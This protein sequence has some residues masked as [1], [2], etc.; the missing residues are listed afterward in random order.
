MKSK[1]VD[2]T[3]KS[4]LCCSCGICKSVC[5]RKCIEYKRESGMYI[6]VIDGSLCIKCGICTDVCPGL[7]HKYTDSDHIRSMTGESLLS[8]NAWSTD[9][10]LRH[11]SASAGC[12]SSLI[13]GLLKKRLYDCAVSVDT[14]DYS[15][16]VKSVVFD[17]NGIESE[18]S[19][20]DYPKSRYLPVS[21]ERA[22]EY[23]LENRDKRVIFVGT[24]CAVRGLV[25]VIEKFKLDRD[26]YLLIGLFCDRVLNY[27][28]YSYFSNFADGRKIAS[29]HFKNKDSGGW[30]G[31]IKLFFTDGTYKFV[32]SSERMKVK[33]FFM[34]ERCLYCLDKLNVCADISVG[35][36]F[37]GEH[38]SEKGSNS[39]IVRTERGVSA[40]E[41]IS[42]SVES[43]PVDVSKIGAV[44][45]LDI[46]FIN[47]Y[48]AE[49]K[50]RN[51]DIDGIY[52]NDKLIISDDPY[53]Y[54]RV[55]RSNLSK[56]KLGKNFDKSPDKYTKRIKRVIDNDRIVSLKNKV[57]AL[58]YGVARRFRRLIKQKNV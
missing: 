28:V 3:A 24:S 8:F 1:T 46:R 44:Q 37:T 39:V 38:T 49:L 5:P 52:L 21:H 45:A 10:R 50:Q 33:E 12:V 22:V 2:F 11:V 40:W 14:Y 30:P 7:S 19:D 48:Y 56:I 54:K 25:N 31:N 17:L 15:D 32:A 6:P 57:S 18:Y 27:N 26:N 36:N 58:Y 9:E 20:S 47:E 4:G 23:I 41:A 35:D 16:R 42:D 51:L 43:Y 55:Y 29:L 13:V 53:E 34:P